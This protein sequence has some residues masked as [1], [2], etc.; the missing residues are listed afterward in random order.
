MA[1]NS[2]SDEDPVMLTYDD[3]YLRQQY[4]LN[5]KR[6]DNWR[7]PS[8]MA[9]DHKPYGLIGEALGLKHIF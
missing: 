5:Y 3:P 2:T 1:R 6:T 8:V 9:W 7:L 4:E